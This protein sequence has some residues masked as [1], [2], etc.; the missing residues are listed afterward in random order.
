M[1]VGG[2]RLRQPRGHSLMQQISLFMQHFRPTVNRALEA[3][4]C[5]N[6]IR[7]KQRFP[8]RL[9][10]KAMPELAQAVHDPYTA[11]H[12]NKP[13]LKQ[14]IVRVD[15]AV[16]SPE[17]ATGPLSAA[18]RTAALT[19]FPIPESRKVKAATVTFTGTGVTSEETES[20][21]WLFHGKEREKTLGITSE[22]L[23]ISYNRYASFEALREEFIDVMNAYVVVYPP[24]QVNRI[25]LRYVNEI[26]LPE[27]NPLDW[28]AYIRQ[29]MLAALE[30]AE[31][32]GL[33][34]RAFQK[35]ELNYGE[36]FIVF[37][38]GI[39]NPDYPATVKR[40]HFVID[41]DGY[42]AGLQNPAE[43]IAHL[44]NAHQTI[45]KLFETSINPALRAKMNG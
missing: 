9:V 36:L 3:V 20:T 35:L 15:W 31:D 24:G 32:K 25:G 41:I 23:F 13:F 6:H 43:V 10:R 19:N 39:S 26:E 5:S 7:L 21:Q 18:I 12:Y 40:K 1:R 16:P 14:V 17:V 38:Y 30:V 29:P 37:Q 22:A 45:Q 4:L 2:A 33:I 11:T 34:A 44:D 42:Y 28:S 27:A 8:L